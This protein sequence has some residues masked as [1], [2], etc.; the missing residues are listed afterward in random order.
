MSQVSANAL[1]PQEAHDDLARLNKGLADTKTLVLEIV[2]EARS[3]RLGSGDGGGNLKESA[4]IIGENKKK[5]DELTVAIRE[6][7]KV[8]AEKAVLEARIAVLESD[9]GKAMV[10]TRKALNDKRKEVSALGSAYK[11]LVL[12][13]NQAVAAAKNAM[14]AEIA[15]GRATKDWSQATKDLVATAQKAQTQLLGLDAVVKDGR[16]NVGNYGTATHELSQLL[17]EMPAFAYSAQTGLLGLSNNIPMFVDKVQKSRAEGQNWNQI[18]KTL[19]VSLLSFNS[20]LTI[21]IGIVT[22]W[23]DKIFGNKEKTE[24]A[25]KANEEYKDSIKSIA[26]EIGK[27]V[28]QLANLYNT[29]T[30]T[31]AS[32]K[33]RGKAVDEL[34]RKWPEYFGNLNREKI[35]NG[36]VAGAYDALTNSIIESAKARGRQ[37]TIT[38]IATELAQAQETYD[39]LTGKGSGANTFVYASPR[40]IEDARKTVEFKKKQLEML[41]KYDQM[42]I[43]NGENSGYW[44]NQEEKALYES[45]QQREKRLAL[46]TEEE[47]KAAAKKGKSEAG[48]IV[49][50]PPADP[51]QENSIL[52]DLERELNIL[53]D[54]WGEID[55]RQT[56]AIK[57][58]GELSDE[59]AAKL[60]A[61]LDIAT[62]KHKREVEYEKEKEKLKEKNYKKEISRIESIL[63]QEEK[64]ANFIL[65]VTSRKTERKLASLD[66]EQERNERAKENEIELIKLSTLTDEQKYEKVALAQAAADEK[67]RQ[68]E[69][70]KA[71]AIRRQANFEKSLAITQIFIELF[72]ALAKET[73]SK[74]AAGLLTGGAITAYVTA[75]AAGASALSVPAYEFGTDNHPGGFALVGEGR[76]P[77]GYKPEL[78]ET[79]DGNSFWVDKPTLLNLPANTSVTPLDEITNRMMLP[80]VMSDTAS[81]DSGMQAIA[82]MLAEGFEKMARNQPQTTWHLRNGEWVKTQQIGNK[83]ITYLNSNF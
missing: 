57:H 78:V 79:P 39:R 61:V 21:G 14:A 7:N 46:M 30:R 44:L 35:L 6:Y 3:I 53:I 42:V 65:S 40:D 54:L 69:E 60:A 64:A 22:I 80:N 24:E 5:Q 49:L 19:G 74:G 66:I 33:E 15:A 52:S 50:E 25:T 70:R 38:K 71:D 73:G 2:K 26:E 72:K 67:S 43:E 36:E 9:A 4:R 75:L 56:G 10:E 11:T 68:I 41:T 12:E 37:A 32:Y 62:L 58:M 13:T 1:I 45:N 63:A 17:R 34:Q 8:V 27:E 83:K 51:S 20:L 77:H 81:H 29:A 23:G 82:N 48:R 55:Y 28:S 47:R 16:R 59:E 18:I 31:T 76:A